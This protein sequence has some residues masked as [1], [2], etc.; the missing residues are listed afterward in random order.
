[1]SVGL[2]DYDTWKSTTPRDLAPVYERMAPD[3]DDAVQTL[4]NLAGEFEALSGG[5]DC[6]ELSEAIHTLANAF[7]V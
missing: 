6:P 2:G 1:M 5:Y 7:N 4:H 3:V